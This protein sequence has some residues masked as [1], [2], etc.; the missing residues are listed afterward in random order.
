MHSL[1]CYGILRVP[2][3]KKDT[4]NICRNL[5]ACLSLYVQSYWTV[6]LSVQSFSPIRNMF[7]AKMFQMPQL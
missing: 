2:S 7:L 3:Q 1:L 5:V 6:F 4:I